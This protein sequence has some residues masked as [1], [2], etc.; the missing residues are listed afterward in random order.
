M[1]IQI[2]KKG[3]GPILCL[4]YF[5]LLCILYIL[6]FISFQSSYD[7]GKIVGGPDVL[8][9]THHITWHRILCTCIVR[10][11]MND[12]FARLCVHGE[13]ACISF[14]NPMYCFLSFF[15]L[16]FSGFSGVSTMG[17]D[18]KL[19]LFSYFFFKKVCVLHRL[20]LFC[21]LPYIM[22]VFQ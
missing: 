1:I 2:P 8:R 5:F 13:C 16:F 11:K 17:F 19:Y 3:W 15:L 4:C 20:L 10:G 6:F 7:G 9:G 21:F 12:V 22:H 18:G 14:V